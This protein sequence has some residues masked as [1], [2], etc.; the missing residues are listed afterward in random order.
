MLAALR[1]LSLTLGHAWLAATPVI[2]APPPNATGVCPTAADVEA[3]LAVRFPGSVRSSS[4]EAA[5]GQ[6]RL[7]TALVPSG[8]RLELRNERGEPLLKR[9]LPREGREEDCRALAESIALIVDRYVRALVPEGAA[10]NDKSAAP[11]PVAPPRPAAPAVAPTRPSPAPPPAAPSPPP[12]AEPVE[13]AEPPPVAERPPT[14]RPAEPPREETTVQAAPPAAPSPAATKPNLAAAPQAEAPRARGGSA[15]ILAVHGGG[16]LGDGVPRG[17]WEGRLSWQRVNAA[18][19]QGWVLE[20]ASGFG[21]GGEVEAEG[22]TVRLDHVPVRLGVGRSF[23]LGFGQLETTLGAGG[24]VVI[25]SSTA[26]NATSPS[27]TWRFAPGVDWQGGFRALVSERVSLLLSVNVGY[28]LM[29]YDVG[30]PHAGSPRTSVAETPRFTL[31][32]L[33]G[34]GVRLW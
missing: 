21:S 28:A 5:P 3:S 8:L 29:Q 10:G 19:A 26:A 17:S 12:A 34:L 2:V 15:H 23:P 13:A 30:V 25:R 1:A 9:L 22:V 27:R 33:L 18:P 14:P 24:D 11:P 20:V 4:A 6:L 31:T 32:P 16:R 7:T